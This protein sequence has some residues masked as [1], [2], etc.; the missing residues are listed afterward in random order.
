MRL[1]FLASFLLVTVHSSS[2]IAKRSA[3]SSGQNLERVLNEIYDKLDSLTRIQTTIRKTTNKN[4]KLLV[5]TRDKF[6]RAKR[7][8]ELSEVFKQK[9][10]KRKGKGR[11]RSSKSKSTSTSS[12]IIDGKSLLIFH[13][14][15]LKDDNMLQFQEIDTEFRKQQ[16]AP[17]EMFLYETAQ[18]LINV[19]DVA[20]VKKWKVTSVAWMP[21]KDGHFGPNMMNLLSDTLRVPV[22]VNLEG[23][24]QVS[25]QVL[26]AE[27]MK[28]QVETTRVKLYDPVDRDLTVQITSMVKLMETL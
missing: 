27:R 1:V 23:L 21:Q 26:F 12:S 24:E 9:S 3:K 2:K 8:N 6:T 20:K 7:S 17:L 25:L 5:E 19:L 18:D 11:K 13:R 14:S 4:K 15:V 22:V 10:R 16:N 28:Q